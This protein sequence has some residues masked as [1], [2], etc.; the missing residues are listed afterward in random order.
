MTQD[1]A[2]PATAPR[3]R[4]ELPVLDG[5]AA[6]DQLV[7]EGCWRPGREGGHDPI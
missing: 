1:L 5:G 3:Q 2:M 7:C 6:R 4:P